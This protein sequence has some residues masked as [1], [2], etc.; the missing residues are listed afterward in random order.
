VIYIYMFGEQS[1]RLRVRGFTLIAMVDP[2]S[3]V[4]AG[5]TGDKDACIPWQKLVG[6]N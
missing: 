5:D 6:Q 3:A 1:L 2:V 4:G